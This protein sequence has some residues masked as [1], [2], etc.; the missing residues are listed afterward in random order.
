VI[1]VDR[2]KQLF[3]LRQQLPVLLVNLWNTR[4]PRGIPGQ[5]GHGTTPSRSSIIM[6]S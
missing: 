2:N 3:K 5:Q 6:P 1:L 4:F